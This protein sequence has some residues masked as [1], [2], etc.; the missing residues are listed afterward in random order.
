MADGDSLRGVL[1]QPFA[2]QVAAFRARLGNLVPTRRWDDIDRAAHDRAFMVAGAMKADLLADLAGAVDSAISEGT[3]LE[4][5]RSQFRDIVERRGWHGWTG[6]GTRRG[7]AWRTRVIYRTNAAT[8]YAAGRWAQLM[9]A[10]FALLVYRHGGSKEP[11]PEHLAWDGLT[12]PPDHEFWAS[13]APPNGWGCSCYVVGA[14]SEAAAARLGGRPD[15]TLPQ[16]WN[17]ADPRTGAPAGI[18]RGWNY[19]PG[20]SA[21]D[22]ILSL[23]DK[24]DHLPAQPSIDLIQDWLR[25]PAFGDWLQRPEGSW[26]L[27]RLRDADAA[28]IG[29]VSPVAELTATAAR[30]QLRAQADLGP[31]DYAA[32]Q[33]I[34][35]EMSGRPGADGSALSFSMPQTDGGAIMVRIAVED[36]VPRILSLQRVTG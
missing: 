23:R 29:A 9:E 27:A 33:R 24:L 16:G 17:R 22:T 12:L 21:V 30:A 13:H 28:S 7:E 15:V 32:I 25:R 8:T 2:E 1:G 19:A 5:F 6:E 18:D 31:G 10:G 35:S 14:R 34:V 36:G 11:R 4:A 20:A 3:G 26:P